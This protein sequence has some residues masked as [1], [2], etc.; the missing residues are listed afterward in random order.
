MITSSA[1]FGSEGSMTSTTAPQIFHLSSSSDSHNVH[2]C[3]M[4]KKFK[5]Y[6]YCRDCIQK[7]VITNKNDQSFNSI[8]K[9]LGEL[10]ENKQL[11]EKN[12]SKILEGRLKYDILQTKIRQVKERNRIMRLAIDQ[13]REQRQTLG[14]KLSDLKQRNQERT[15]KLKAYKTKSESLEDCV[16]RKREDVSI[17]QE[18]LKQKYV[19][20]KR[21]AKLRV[22]QLFKYIFP[23]SV[24]KPSV[25]MESSGDSTSRELAEA[26]QTTYLKDRWVY[27]DYSNE[28]QYSVVGPCLPGSGNYSNYILWAHSHD[29]MPISE[30]SE[31]IDLNPAVSISSALALTAQLVNVLSFILNVR[32]PFKSNYSDFDSTHLTERQFNRRV[33]RLNANVLYLCITQRIDLGQLSPTGTIR[34]ILQ[35]AENE[36]ADLGRQGPIVINDR[37]ARA[38]E[39]SISGNLRCPDDSDWDEGDSFTLEWEAVPHVQLPEAP[40]GVASGVSSLINTQQASSIVTS[41]VAGVASIWRGII[42]R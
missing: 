31:I 19:E 39:R 21:L 18:E 27:T 30:D 12:C 6:F 13:K 40:A 9:A 16:G 1:E 33:A 7:G 15:E 25:E 17:A 23:I 4:C 14:Q 26:C 24:V 10:N 37:Q 35:L 38:L 11:I 41:A 20:I 32:L 3:P 34:N 22:Q 29:S 42:H 5:K 2:K 28:M 36:R 8:K